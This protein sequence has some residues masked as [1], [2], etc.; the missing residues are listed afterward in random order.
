MFSL[1]KSVVGLAL[2]DLGISKCRPLY[3]PVIILTFSPSHLLT[4]SLSHLLTFSPSLRQQRHQIK[5]H[6]LDLGGRSPV[7]FCCRIQ[8]IGFLQIASQF[9]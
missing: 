9:L 1:A 8:R 6:V 7:E 5:G 3:F 4:F 2:N